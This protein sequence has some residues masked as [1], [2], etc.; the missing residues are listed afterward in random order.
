M[1]L[2]YFVL[3]VSSLIFIH[4]S[5]HFA[6]AKIFGVKVLTFSIGFGPNAVRIRGKETEY[7]LGI[8]P[9]GGF[10]KML[11][12][13]KRS[14]PIL[15]EERGRTFEA[16][17]L[18]KRVVIVLAGP[19]M[20]VLFPVV[21]YTS[22]FLEQTQFL[23][24][25]VGVVEPGMPADGKLEPGD[26][27]LSV[28]GDAVTTNREVQRAV[29]GRANRP[30]KLVVER[31]GKT[32]DVAVTP[33]DIG[34]IRELDIV[35]HTGRIGFDARFPAAV[36]GISR[37]DSPAGTGL[38]TFDR[39]TAV[40]GRRIER[41]VDL[42]DLLSDNRGDQVVV[43]Y[44][45]PVD[46]PRALGGL[47]ELAVL[48]PG[49]ATITPLPRLAGATPPAD[50]I[51]RAAD[52][53]ARTGIESADMYVAFVPKSSSE[54]LAGLQPGD[55]MTTLDG[56]PQRLWRT[57]EDELVA[58][59]D[60]ERELQWTRDGV[61][62]AG[63]FRLRKEQWDDDFDTHYERYVFRTDHWLPPAPDRL[64]PNPHPLLGA[65][66]RAVEE[67]A[68]VIKFISI[69][70]LRLAQGRVSLSSVSGPITMYDIAG[71]AAARGT[72]NFVRT[73][74]VISINLGLLNLLPIPVLDGGHL[75]FFL[76]EAARRQPLAAARARDREPRRA[77]GAHRADGRGLQER[78]RAA[79]GRH[80][81]AGARA[82]V[83][84]RRSPAA[85]GAEGA[86]R[87]EPAQRRAPIGPSARELAAR[88][89]VR[90]HD[91]GA[92]AAAA[93]EA[94]LGRAVQ[95]EARDR[96]L[97]TELV[98]GALRVEPWL[99]ER[100]ARF[101]PRG[102]GAVD[103]LVRAHLV[104]AAYQLWFT[105]VPA[106]A[107]VNEAVRLVRGGRGE[108][109]A[110]FVNAVLRK[111][112]AEAEG[113]TRPERRAEAIVACTPPWLREALARA[114]GDDGARTMLACGA[115]PPAVALRVERADERDAWL[116][117][118]RAT[119]PAASF[120][121]GRVSPHA[122]LARGAG[123]PQA[124]PGWAEGAWSVQEEGS[125][126]AALAV[127]ARP[128]E[129]VLDA[130][131]GRGNKTGLLV[132]AVQTGA[133]AGAVDACD[134]NPTKLER[135]GKELGR[136][137]LV[138]RA[139]YAVDWTVGS[140]DVPPAYDRVLVDAPCTGTGTLRRRPEIALRREAGD[141]AERTRAQVAI[142]TRAAAHV[143]PGGS[144]VYVVCS[145][146]RE[147][148]EDVLDAVLRA[149]P[150]L[151]PA[152]FDAPA[153]QAIAGNAPTLRLLPHVHGTDAYFVARMV[154]GTK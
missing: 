5:G 152:A 107:A 98:Y 86:L 75:L 154:R 144:L 10:V 138:A 109:I 63:H 148:C 121:A 49:A 71:Q 68:S 139:T 85:G 15:P 131:A 26:R 116:A 46:V 12:E 32:L 105:R 8:L 60:K 11:E 3:L 127:G 28:D 23:P 95:L 106:F 125:Q 118:L 103:A 146:L 4:E 59:A 67:T 126:L 91:D 61:P 62:M 117:A 101:M 100:A 73:M 44:L 135:L 74:A 6:F 122:I 31:D 151:A 140:G 137:G 7:C 39:V 81:D 145:V 27:F 57:M 16:Q 94:Q 134:G 55:R 13:S 142:A 119:A 114:I 123:K 18:W 102:I 89:I 78:R 113:E 84:R 150:E 115:E 143:R 120:E 20:N 29:A 133:S 54:A 24:P 136:L 65:M 47:C 112:A 111:V 40:N 42:V 43:S 83:L 147:E 96:A 14:E 128:G 52:V 129:V 53:L 45:R 149:R 1:D 90:V 22:V 19:A 35:E 87:T 80:R 104:V 66:R 41:F 2:L 56:V 124:L 97:A 21:L 76:L 37:H 110:A 58:G 70:M 130:C 25:V 33:A 99:L 92:F 38:R 9:F 69:G 132:R 88:V 77:R 34:E 153:A 141:L 50:A 82:V 17:A 79:V 30:V 36:V 51:A 64:V 48:E 93:L 72:S 108:R